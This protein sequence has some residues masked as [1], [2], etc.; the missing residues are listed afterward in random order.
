LRKRSAFFRQPLLH[1]FALM[2]RQKGRED[3][4]VFGN[5]RPVHTFSDVHID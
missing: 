5:I 1:E 3:S 4:A 2:G